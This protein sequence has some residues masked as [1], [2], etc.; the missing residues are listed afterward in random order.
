MALDLARTL[1]Q[2]EAMAQEMQARQEERARRLQALL[3]VAASLDPQQVNRRAEGWLPYLD[4]LPAG[5][6]T[7]VAGAH[8]APDPPA[9]Y[10][11]VA[12]DGSHIDVDR[13]LPAR[14]YLIN[15]GYCL[16][17]Y[18]GEP[19]ARLE[20]DPHLYAAEEE[21]AL[22][23]PASGQEVAVE[24]ALLGLKRTVEEFKALVRLA[25]G[26]PPDRPTLALVDGSLVLWGLAGGRESAYPQFVRHALLRDGLAPALKEME[27]LA[28]GRE[29]LP[30]G[31]ISLPRGAE[32]V[33]ALRVALCPQEPPVCS[34]WRPAPEGPCPCLAGHGVS[35]RELFSLLLRPGQRSPLFFT[36]S[37]VVRQEYPWKVYFFYLHTGGEVARVEVPAWVAESPR[38]LEMA[39]SLVL[40][41]VRRGGGYPQAL[42]EAHEQAV[43]TGADREAFRQMVHRVLEGHRLPVYTSEKARSKRVRWL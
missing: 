41:Q 42:V 39:H 21:L 31:Y 24:G 11:V 17:K 22:R 8:P 2:V 3:E 27:R 16:I 20:S 6:T 18:G 4:V 10:S 23:D 35:D 34:P 29:V 9:S 5:L 15:L 14:C 33:N 37:S 38:R 40:D 30:A 7:G 19:G 1:S 32:V 26:A 36:R 28:K 12:V 13:H 43:V 25:G